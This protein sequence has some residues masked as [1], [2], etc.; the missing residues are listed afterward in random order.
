M[1]ISKKSWHYKLLVAMGTVPWHRYDSLC[2]YFWGLVFTLFVKL[3]FS[4]VAVV[5]CSPVIVIFITIFWV[6]DKLQRRR[7]LKAKEDAKKPQ[8]PDKPSK[9]CNNEPWL[10]T[11]W[12]RAKKDKVCPLIEWED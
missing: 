5:L 6:Q 7:W 1:R 2:G 4:L 11:A 10:I 8:P 9:L 12:L 3:P